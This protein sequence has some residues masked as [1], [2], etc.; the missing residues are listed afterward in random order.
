MSG[1]AT[2]EEQIA[3]GKMKLVGDRK[4]YDQLKSILVQFPPDTVCSL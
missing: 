2:F 1:K 3:A 4:P